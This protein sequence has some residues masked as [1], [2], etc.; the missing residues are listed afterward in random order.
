AS[1]APRIR[2]WAA[3]AR[4]RLGPIAVLDT[5]PVGAPYAGTTGFGSPAVFVSEDLLR[6]TDWR[7]QDALIG[8]VLGEARF[9]RG[10][11]LTKSLHALAEG[12]IL[13][14]LFLALGALDHPGV[15]EPSGMGNTV[16]RIPLVVCALSLVSGLRFLQRLL[17]GYSSSHHAQLGRR[18][19]AGLTG[20]PLAVIVALHTFGALSLARLS[21]GSRQLSLLDQ[22]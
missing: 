9:R 20:D 8:L 17:Y 7:Q 1:L 18:F 19:A 21:L 3:Y 6:A 10:I 15:P 4:L 13:A 12:S 11:H 22:V 16:A 5:A 14:A 2:A